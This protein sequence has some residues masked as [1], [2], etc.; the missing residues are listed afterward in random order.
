MKDTCDL[1]PTQGEFLPTQGIYTLTLSWP[2]HLVAPIAKTEMNYQ[3]SEV[4][5]EEVK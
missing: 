2:R 5:G 1:A 3:Q 4:H